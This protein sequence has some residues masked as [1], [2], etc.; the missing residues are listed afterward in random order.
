MRTRRPVSRHRRASSPSHNEVGGFVFDFE[1]VRPAQVVI[2]SRPCYKA[3][4]SS[5]YSIGCSSSSK[6]LK[7]GYYFFRR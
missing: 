6:T 4:A 3:A 7:L 5:L 1:A 2:E